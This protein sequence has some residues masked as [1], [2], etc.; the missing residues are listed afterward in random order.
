MSDYFC[1]RV[2]FLDQR[3]HGRG[4]GDEPEWP[5]SPLRVFQALVA[6][7]A[8]H[9][10]ERT[11]ITTAAAALRW[12]ETMPCPAIIAPN[13]RPA[14]PYRLYV[15]NNTGDLAASSWASHREKDLS[16]FRTEKDVHPL[17]LTDGDT[18]Y[19]LWKATAET[20]EGSLYLSQISEATRAI[21]HLGWGI[22]LVNADAWIAS[23]HEC[24][25][26]LGRRWEPS[27]EET[28]TRFPVPVPG[29][30]NALHRRHQSYLGRLQTESREKLL[31]PVPRMTT[32]RRAHYHHPS[33]PVG[34]PTLAFTLAP[35]A[36]NGNARYQAY[37]PVSQ[38]TCVAAMVRHILNQATFQQ[39]LGWSDEKLKLLHGHGE[40]RQNPDGHQPVDGPR[41]AILPIPS[42]EYRGSGNGTVVGATRRVLLTILQGEATSALND[43]CHLVEGSELIPADTSTPPAVLTS[44][45]GDRQTK[46]YTGHASTWATVT[47]VVLP[48]FDDPR[49]LR[50]RLNKRG[51]HKI[52]AEEKNEIVRKLDSRIEKLLR[53]ALRQAGYS[54]E[55][56][57][58]SELSWRASGFWP[59]T[60]MANE[61]FVPNHLQRFRKLHVKITWKDASGQLVKVPGPLVLGSGR[62]VGI[63]LFA[64]LYQHPPKTT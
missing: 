34:R 43:L 60:A 20:A 49:R 17:N 14:I 52:T 28:G 59:G 30:F 40:T 18:V 25:K 63:G 32:L 29:T 5:P 61:Y 23:S 44:L 51:G 45:V 27:D 41:L 15:P 1:I 12:L 10:N 35:L 57:E 33:E 38:N 62:F 8:A 46:P 26:L 19:Y 4:E 36:P 42:F 39:R 54:A 7:C 47:P 22:D 9:W 13:V 64:P 11:E 48:G 53:K 24:L 3:F 16:R 50:K 21:T 55:L 31:I 37:D 58:R 56:A 2:Q 6:A